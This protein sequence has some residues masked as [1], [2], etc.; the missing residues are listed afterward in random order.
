MTGIFKASRTKVDLGLATDITRRDFV[1]GALA[2]AGAALM[3]GCIDMSGTTGKEDPFAPSGS[4]WT[5]YGGVGDYARSNGNTHAVRDAAHGVRDGAYDE[6][7]AVAP[8]ENYDLVIVGGGFSGVTAAYEF[9]KLAKPGQTCLL[10]ENHPV[11]GGEAKHNVIEVDGRR[12]I[13]PQGSNE[14]LVPLQSYGER[15]EVF[16]EYW[17]E[18]GM[19][20]DFPLVPLAGGAEKYRIPNSHYEPMVLEREYEVGYFFGNDG[21]RNNPW[22]NGFRD[23]PWPERV[24][25]EADDYF[26]NRRDLVSTIGAPDKVDLF[27]DSMTYREL[28]DRIGYGS[29][30]SRLTD[31]LIGVGNHGVCGDAISAYAAR[32]L[33]L[34]GTLPSDEKSRFAGIKTVSFPGGNAAILRTMLKRLL[35]D[36]VTG[37]NSLEANAAAP[38][39]FAAFD[40]A[41]RPVRMRLAS[42]AVRVEH[43][44]L[45]GEAD[46][47]FVTY[48]KDGK[49]NRV[50][51][52][53]VI[54]AGGGWVNRRV[55]RDMPEDIAAAYADF[56]YGPVLTVN[57]ALRH[58]RFFDK[59]GIVAA[60]WFEGLGWH[61]CIRRNVDMGGKQEPLTPDSPIMMTLYIPFLHPGEDKSVQGSLGRQT[62]LDTSYAD[63]ERQIREQLTAMFGAAG[64]NAKRDI[65]GIVLNRWGH[66]YLAPA[67]GFFFGRDG[68]PAPHAIIR[69][70]YGRVR[71]ANS[72]LQGNM[73]MAHAMLEGRR[74]AREVAQF[75]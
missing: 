68:Q 25:R 42:T 50:A 33:T 34:P 62:L 31:P 61:A 71:F 54:M 72:E 53:S 18:I 6:I 11:P 57:I 26:N 13:G 22:K 56:N 38:F 63:F 14:A 27:L 12:L 51:A 65:A 60:R 30:V 41:D 20:Y 39:D 59:L 5:G 21:W 52:K 8:A 36:S 66:A 64:F 10:L 15:Y 48:V 47:A 1:N 24:Q 4:P 74:A 40:R 3:S 7:A 9:A 29:E 75:I 23:T 2:G 73:N 17:Q 70:G 44:G 67:P 28:L 46:R 16:R 35:P 32:R 55:L 58:W 45:P 43:D 69:K 49:L 19:P 37:D